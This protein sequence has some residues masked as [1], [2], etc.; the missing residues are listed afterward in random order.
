MKKTILRT[1][2][3][4]MLFSFGLSAVLLH[5]C[6]KNVS[7]VYDYAPAVLAPDFEIS[8]VNYVFNNEALNSESKVSFKVSYKNA[9]VTGTTYSSV[10]NF[11]VDGNL[12]KSVSLKDLAGN[13]SYETIFD[14]EAIAGKHDFKFEINLSSGGSTIVEEANAKNNTQTTSL[15]IAVKQL[16]A[17][18]TAVVTPTVVKQAITADPVANVT[19]VLTN[20][21]LVVST[22]VEAVKTTYSSGTTAIIAAVAKSDG[23]TDETKVVLSAI[24]NPGVLQGQTQEAKTTL[25]VETL[26]AKKEVSFYNAKEKLT[27]TDGVVSLLGLKS[28]KADCTEPSNLQALNANPAAKKAYSD[29]VSAAINTLGVEKGL[30]AAPGILISTL[31]AYN[32]TQGDIDNPPTVT[33]EIT[34]SSEKCSE[35]CVD[36]FVVNTFS[37]PGF[38]LRFTDDRG[39]L[40]DFTKEPNC[41]ASNNGTY[42]FTDCGGKKVSYTF[43]STRPVIITTDP[44]VSNVHN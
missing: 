1:S 37:Y 16:A 24:S 42:T 31:E 2:A 10:L 14:W 38:I 41:S 21:G 5:S 15:T 36:G 9:E 20:E 34:N 32:L 19:N 17:V 12:Q 13:T 23:T 6:K 29:A 30:A 33:S 39:T 3:V 7:D 27:Y 40:P 25:V 28:A 26:V 11:F 8:T 43:T 35:N 44:C 4:V 22:K 18:S